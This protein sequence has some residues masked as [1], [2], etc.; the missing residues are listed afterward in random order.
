MNPSKLLQKG[1]Y[2]LGWK[3]E[4]IETQTPMAL[5][6]Y[7][8]RAISSSTQEEPQSSNPVIDEDDRTDENPARTEA[9]TALLTENPVFGNI[10]EEVDLAQSH[11]HYLPI[12]IP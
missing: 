8:E 12:S 3:Q 2:F 7:R 11:E 6:Q 1:Q 10:T 4:E 9:L 5:T